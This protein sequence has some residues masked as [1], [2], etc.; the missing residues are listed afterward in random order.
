MYPDVH[1]RASYCFPLSDNPAREGRPYTDADGLAEFHDTLRNILGT[2][3]SGVF[4]ATPEEGDRGNC[5]Y[6][7]FNRLCPAR[8]RQIWERKGRNDPDVQ[9]FNALGGRAAIETDE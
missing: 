8:R 5:R 1:I 6:C 7:D 4:P 3:R 9:A 2:A